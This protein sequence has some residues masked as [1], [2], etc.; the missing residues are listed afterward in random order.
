MKLSKIATS[1]TAN[2][3]VRNN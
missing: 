3:H 2:C 1:E